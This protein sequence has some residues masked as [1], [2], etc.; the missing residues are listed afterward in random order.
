MNRKELE[1]KRLEN[2]KKLDRSYRPK[3]NAVE[4]DTNNSFK[5]EFSKF[6]SVFL[7]RAGYTADE[8]SILIPKIINRK[9]KALLKEMHYLVARKY[10]FP[11]KKIIKPNV[12]TEARFKNKRRADIFVLDT[13]EIV[14][15]ETN[16]KVKKKGA[17]TI[18]I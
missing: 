7:L 15:I 9:C 12:V 16:K 5:H 10:P 11:R 3:I 14:E 1:L 4:V 2:L 6:L 18:Y 13:G 17:I 8:L